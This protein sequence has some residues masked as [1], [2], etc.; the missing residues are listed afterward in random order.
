MFKVKILCKFFLIF[1][2]ITCLLLI[3][4]SYLFCFESYFVFSIPCTEGFCENIIYL[5]F[6]TTCK[7]KKKKLFFNDL[8]YRL[9]GIFPFTHSFIHSMQT[10]QSFNCLFIE[11]LFHSNT[12]S[13]KH[14]FSYSMKNYI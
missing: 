10:L 8:T 3:L 1:H 7:I 13:F 2:N 4:F 14:S 6:N 9:I 12:Q 5:Q 11:S